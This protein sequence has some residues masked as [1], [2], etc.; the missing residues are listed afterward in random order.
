MTTAPPDGA[1][2]AESLLAAAASSPGFVDALIAANA[3]FH[4]EARNAD[5]D[6]LWTEEVR[7]VVTTVGKQAMLDACFGARAKDSWF[8]LLKGSGA[9]AKGDTLASHATWPEVT[10]YT[11]NRPAVAF[12]AATVYSTTGAQ[13]THPAITFTI[14][15]DNTTIAG[16]GICNA[17]TGTTG[18]LY[19][20]G[21]FGSSRVLGANDNIN[22]TAILQQLP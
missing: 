17:A 21:D 11:G 5:G 15:A 6:L 1:A 20:A 18:L 8:M 16:L 4:V 9:A 3:V 10:A 22:V 7:N 13:V 14:N 2:P 19:N 12:S